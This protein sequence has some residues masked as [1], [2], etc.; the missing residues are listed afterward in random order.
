MKKAL[1]IS[2]AGTL[3][4]FEEDAYLRL[5]AYF[6]S[7]KE[8][9]KNTQGKEEIISDIESRVVEQLIDSKEKIITLPTVEKVIAVMGKV[10]DFGDSENSS[11]K[12]EENGTKGTRN[13][14]KKLYRNPDDAIIAGVC[15]GLA[16]YI[17]VD[18]VWVRLL[19]VLLTFGS[20][21][22]V[23]LYIVLWIITPEAKTASHKL[24]MKGEPVTLET[25]S[26][27]VKDRVEEIKNRPDNKLARLVSLPFRILG[28]AIK[29]VVKI[30]VPLV[31]I[32]LGIAL[33]V[34]S[35]IAIAGVVTV[36][37]FL[38]SGN[39]QIVNGLPVGALLPGILMPIIISGVTLAIVIPVIF[40][41]LAGISLL[42]KKSA[43]SGTMSSAIAGL[44]FVSLVASGFGAAKVASNY[45]SFIETS[46]AFQ[47]VEVPVT[48]SGEFDKLNVSDGMDIQII[49]GKDV[50]LI[51]K[52]RSGEI[53]SV[54]I[55]VIDGVLSINHKNLNNNGRFC[56]F[57][58]AGNPELL[59]TVPYLTEIKAE[60]GSA[61]NSEAFP[62]ADSLNIELDNGSY[63]NL[64]LK[65]NMV[66]V[67]I[68]QGSNLVL[69]GEAGSLKADL[70]HGSDL[71]AENFKVKNAE[72]RASNGSHAE[73]E[74]SENLNAL[75]EFGSSIY[76]SGNPTVTE[77]EKGGS[78]IS[79]R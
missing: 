11:R 71:S 76:Y 35:M 68:S 36:S 5:E 46:P 26:E 32:I 21:V 79:P 28:K 27:T 69:N 52:G 75:A 58:S 38:F 63:S 34:G 61:I 13:W 37:G 4:T 65:A 9:F 14:D 60:R 17:G 31:R 74:V 22:G 20:G 6:A 55:K 48:L 29:F 50:S 72:I 47:T 59:L 23:L 45:E 7:I 62:E 64:D 44:W 49:S 54:D 42:K 1:Q 2:I 66:S 51:V 8:H 41:F 33:T 3:F 19:F 16:A 78:D 25:L 43:I 12:N 70:K 53:E 56:L 39:V 10:E 24:E 67:S 57:C 77:E 18:P 15:S 30:I 40:I 73:I